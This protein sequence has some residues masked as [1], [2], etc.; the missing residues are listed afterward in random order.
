MCKIPYEQNRVMH[1]RTQISSVLLVRGELF[2]APKSHILPNRPFRTVESG[3]CLFERGSRARGRTVHTSASATWPHARD[4]GRPPNAGASESSC[5][6][7]RFPGQ[8]VWESARTLIRSTWCFGL[9]VPANAACVRAD[10]RTGE[11]RGLAVPRVVG[12]CIRA[13]VS[14]A[15]VW[16]RRAWACLRIRVHL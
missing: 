15:R 6:R 2:L 11:E 4:T 3:T 16:L 9:K 5:G 14:W 7:T 13:R 12:G 1:T 8:S 10:E